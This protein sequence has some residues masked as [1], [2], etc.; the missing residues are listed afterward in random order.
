MLINGKT[1]P[2]LTKICKNVFVIVGKRFLSP[3]WIVYSGKRK[4][5]DW[6]WLCMLTDHDY[7][8]S[9][10]WNFSWIQCCLSTG[11]KIWAWGHYVI[12]V[13]PVSFQCPVFTLVN[14]FPQLH[15]K[16]VITS[17]IVLQIDHGQPDLNQGSNDLGSRLFSLVSLWYFI[18]Y[19]IMKAFLVLK[20]RACLAA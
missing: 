16:N 12:S 18:S 13:F 10:A 6:G 4:A 8:E 17:T 9:H 14:A 19:D 20:H 15:W 5:W 3:T 1:A 2:F 7:C 11:L